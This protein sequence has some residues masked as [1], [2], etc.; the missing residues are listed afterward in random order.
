[1]GVVICIVPY[2]GDHKAPGWILIA[3][4]GLTF[5]DGLICW[6]HW[7]YVP[8]LIGHGSLWIGRNYHF[9]VMN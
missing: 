8:V 4:R 1:M 9:G 7:C 2:F 5:T 3:P 6:N